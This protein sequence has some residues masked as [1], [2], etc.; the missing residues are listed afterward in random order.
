MCAVRRNCAEK[1]FGWLK[2]ITN[3]AGIRLAA[4]KFGGGA[5]QVNKIWCGGARR[6]RR[7]LINWLVLLC[8]RGV[9]RRCRLP[10]V[11]HRGCGG[12]EA[13]IA[14]AE[15]DHQRRQPLSCLLQLCP[16]RLRHASVSSPDPPAELKE[17]SQSLK[18]SAAR[19]AQLLQPSLAFCF[20]LQPMTAHW[21]V[22]RHWLQTTTK[23]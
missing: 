23:C 7:G 2:N 5:A 9:I 12:G 18:T 16:Y 10:G 3:S 19:L 13:V 15:S 1:I 6:R 21:T 11:H 4:K 22:R 20:S 8:S 14:P 17:R